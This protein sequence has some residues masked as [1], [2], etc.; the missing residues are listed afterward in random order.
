MTLWGRVRHRYSESRILKT[1][2][3]SI[4]TSLEQACVWE[5]Q[6]LAG[7]H[8]LHASPDPASTASPELSLTM[9]LAR[10]ARPPRPHLATSDH[11]CALHVRHL[12]PGRPVKEQPALH[13]LQR[14]AA[15]SY[16]S[17][18]LA[19]L[20]MVP[21]THPAVHA[22]ERSRIHAWYRACRGYV[23]LPDSPSHLFLHPLQAL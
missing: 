9:P 7:L 12:P 22:T 3:I 15:C 11:L 5:G 19:S 2:K 21:S 18:A 20:H 4:T 16:A 1:S 8:G 10:Q 6:E 23:E 14:W 17:D 13:D